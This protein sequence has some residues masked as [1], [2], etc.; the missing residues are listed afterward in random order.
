M[1]ALGTEGVCPICNH[2]TFVV[3][4]LSVHGL[5]FSPDGEW[6]APLEPH[7]VR[8]RACRRCGYLQ[9]FVELQAPYREAPISPE[10]GLE[11][12]PSSLQEEPGGPPLSLKDRLKR[13]SEEWFADN[14]P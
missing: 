3:G 10:S 13:A 9:L 6:P 11:E 14:E 7:W 8:G 1:N 5:T 2:D 4:R 12:L